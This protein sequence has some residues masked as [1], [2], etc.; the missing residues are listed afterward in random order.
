MGRKR[1]QGIYARQASIRIDLRAYGYGLERLD[2][3]PTERNLLHAYKLRERCIRQIDAGT[4]K[5]SEHFPASPRATEHRPHAMLFPELMDEWLLV[6]ADEIAATTVQE[7]RNALTHYF[8][9]AWRTAPAQDLSLRAVRLRIASTAWPSLKT[10]NN[11]VNALRGLL[12]YGFEIRA[13]A[14]NIAPH[15][16]NAKGAAKPDPDPLSLDEIENLLAVMREIDP[17]G[18]DYYEFAFF[19]GLR[20]SEQIA[21]EWP[22]VDLVGSSVRVDAARVRAKDKDT[23]TH[24]PRDVELLARPR[25]ALERQKARSYLSG[26]AVFL[27]PRTG[28]RFKSTEDPLAIWWKPAMKR[29]GLRQRDAR[30]TRHSFA[31]FAIMHK[32]DPAWA[33][34]QMGHSLEVFYRRYAKWIKGADRSRNRDLLDVAARAEQGRSRNEQARVFQSRSKRRSG[35]P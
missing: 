14:E 2:L 23:K 30:Q 4:F 5:L 27:N 21:L 11:V 31:T 34:D 26:G 13:L 8:V 22:K 35:S 24:Q 33:A 12:A 6:K 29:A 10:R 7:Y 28:D 20:P 19:T 3:I 18:A 9:P 25:S 16:K 32:A 1:F 17:A 15:L